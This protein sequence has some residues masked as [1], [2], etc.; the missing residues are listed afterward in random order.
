MLYIDVGNSLIKVAEFA[1]GEWS[2]KLRVPHDKIGDALVW[3]GMLAKTGESFRMCS[4]VGNIAD[5]ICSELGEKVTHVTLQKIST[6]I[7]DY[8]TPQTL[9]LDRVLACYGA[10][11]LSQ[12]Q[13][14]IVVDAGTAT[15]I[16]FMDRNGVFRGG[17]IAPGIAA[18]EHGL[19][20]HAPSLPVVDRVRPAIWPPKS[21]TEALQ[22][23][24]TGSFQNMVRDHVQR[25]LDDDPESVI[26]LSGGDA[27]IL[28]N[29]G[30]KKTNY[31]PNLVFE[32]LR[33]LHI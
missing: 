21:T 2:M 12:K 6:S 18:M 26:W 27:A 7:L 14:V 32:G 17:V 33:L 5:R 24:L 10:W 9:G 13:S 23:G 25:F 11:L 3:M 19:R 29:L 28:M 15:T 16:D 8:K 4:V 20:N 31:H 22:W 30:E 1:E